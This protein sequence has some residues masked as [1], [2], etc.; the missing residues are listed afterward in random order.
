MRIL[1]ELIAPAARMISAR[2]V[3][4]AAIRQAHAAGTV[5]RDLDPVDEAADHGAIAGGQRGAQIGIRRRPAPA[6]PD[7]ALECAEAFLPL[8][9]VITRE[10]RSPPP[11]RID[12][13]LEQ[14]VFLLATRDVQRPVRPAPV[15]SPAGPVPMLHPPEIGQHVGIGP[16]VGA[17][18]GPCVI[19]AGMAAHVD[20]AVD[21]RRPADHLAARAGHAAAAHVRLGLG[22]VAPVVARH[23]HRVGQRGGH[24][25]EGAGIGAAMLD[26]EH[27]D[28]PPRPAD[29]RWHTRR[30]LRR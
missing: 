27:L 17:H 24:L 2:A 10:R 18:L 28:D 19:V 29:R 7:C 21:R 1:G 25:D 16:A 3:D 9:V 8:A 22:L 6:L 4:Q 26:D 11:R 15:A 14:R 12:K 13:G 23:V 20:H 30:S 5:L